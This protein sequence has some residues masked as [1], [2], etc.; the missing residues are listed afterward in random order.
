M[1]GSSNQFTYQL[2]ATLVNIGTNAVVQILPP[3]GC[4]GVYFGWQSGGSLAIMNGAGT[5]GPLGGY[6]LGTTEHINL[7][8]PATFFLGAGGAT[9]IAAVVWKYSAGY[10]L[11][12]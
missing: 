3:R 9:A 12:P 11:L 5:S 1:A 8:G 10:S 2:G 4:N 6:L 7:E